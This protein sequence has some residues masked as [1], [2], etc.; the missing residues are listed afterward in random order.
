M[1]KIMNIFLWS[2]KNVK[3]LPSILALILTQLLIV[4]GFFGVLAQS[5][6]S[7]M[8]FAPVEFIE[9]GQDGTKFWSG[10]KMSIANPSKAGRDVFIVDL[11]FEFYGSD[12]FVN[13]GDLVGVSVDDLSPSTRAGIIDT[14]DDQV[15]ALLLN[16]PGVDIPSHL[17]RQWIPGADSSSTSVLAADTGYSHLKD[18]GVEKV[19]VMFRNMAYVGF[20]LILVA[21]GFMIMFRS[22]IGGQTAVT[23]MNSLPSIVIGLV[24]VTFSFA[25]VGFVID[26]SRLLTAVIRSLL[27]EALPELEIAP[28]GGPMQMAWYAFTNSISSTVSNTGSGGL[29]GGAILVA[30]GLANPVTGLI[31]LGIG[32]IVACM[33]GFICVYAAVKL[34]FV[35]VMSYVKILMDLVLGPI[36]LLVGSLPGGKESI[37]NWIKRLLI[38]S[39]TFPIVFF[40]IN[41]FRYLGNP[42]VTNPLTGNFAGFMGGGEDIGDP[43]I[44]LKGAVVIAGYFIAATAPT[45]IQDMFQ[46]RESPGASKAA[47]DIQ[48]SASKIP[49]IGGMFGG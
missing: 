19:W 26:L 30:I 18:L 29:L 43:M 40:I 24:L 32:F 3:Y 39:L 25:I 8:L 6:S 44:S 15:I 12:R 28:I 38:N 11:D 13:R 46:L 42:D 36:Y 9:E 4:S 22:K 17:A 5:G 20:V 2:K 7:D 27:V 45:I 37:T 10:D 34:F 47:Q 49:L 48:K 14:A 33:V 31:E 41:L 16:P 35:L 21:A 1:K 23:V